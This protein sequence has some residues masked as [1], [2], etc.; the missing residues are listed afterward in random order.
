MA[1]QLS[2]AQV[3]LIE[4]FKFLK[5]KQETIVTILLLIP[6]NDQIASMA[7]FILGNMNATESEL[8]EMAIKIAD[9]TKLV[10]TPRKTKGI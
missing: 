5:V 7:E 8:L 9:E 4:C 3:N 1:N 6:E 10:L 2:E